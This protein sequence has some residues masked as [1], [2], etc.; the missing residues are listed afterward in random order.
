ML[1]EPHLLDGILVE[2][3]NIDQLLRVMNQRIEVLL[4]W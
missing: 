3:V 1:P 2:G 4:D